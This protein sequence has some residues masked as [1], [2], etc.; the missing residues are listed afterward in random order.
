MYLWVVSWS[1]TRY[2]SAALAILAMIEAI[3]FPIPPD[4]L[5]IPLSVT[6]PKR[7]LW[8]AFITTLF[9]VIGGIIAYGIGLFLFDWIGQPIISYLGY[10]Q[11]FLAVGKLYSDNAFLAV[12][13]G[14]ITPIPYKVFTIAAGFWKINLLTFITASIIGRAGRFFIVG[15]LFHLFGSRVEK[16]IKKYFE[17]LVTAVFI[18]IVAGIAAVK[19]LI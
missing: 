1:R 18:L 5:Q 15:I 12:L 10:E 11:Q 4:V 16:F 17:I 2:S 3:F 9:S 19:F 13:T 14:A 7:S 8:Y 6:H